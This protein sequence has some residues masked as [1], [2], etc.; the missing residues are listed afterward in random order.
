[1]ERKNISLSLENIKEKTGFLKRYF[2]GKVKQIP[3]KS[4]IYNS[5]EDK[6][7]DYILL[8]ENKLK[9]DPY[10][11]FVKKAFDDAKQ[12]K[13]WEVLEHN[14]ANEYIPTGGELDYAMSGRRMKESDYVRIRKM[15]PY[16]LIEK[17]RELNKEG[18]ELYGKKNI[19][20]FEEAKKTIKKE[21]QDWT[22]FA[23]FD[24]RFSNSK[25]LLR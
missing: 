18:I 5:I 14:L 11:P 9:K 7:D 10:L 13:F 8:V 1:M 19:N 15:I 12:G 4:S 6:F 16:S 2:F 25:R 22:G 17:L 3:Q 20:S 21:K 24:I 23:S